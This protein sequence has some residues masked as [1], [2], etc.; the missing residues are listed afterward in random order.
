VTG[1]GRSSTDINDLG[2]L[3]SIGASTS[4]LQNLQV[5]IVPFG[6]CISKIPKR[7]TN[8]NHIC[9]GGE[10]GCFLYSFKGVIDTILDTNSGQI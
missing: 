7:I 3:E 1:W 9:A 8:E 10:E 5:P 2:T 6:E 4:I